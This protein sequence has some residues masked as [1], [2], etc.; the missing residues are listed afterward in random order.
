MNYFGDISSK[1]TLKP[2]SVLVYMYVG[3]LLAIVVSIIVTLGYDGKIE[4]R[5]RL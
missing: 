1:H 5:Y 4:K 3:R 2:D